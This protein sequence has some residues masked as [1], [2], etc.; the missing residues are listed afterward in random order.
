MS[1]DHPEGLPIAMDHEASSSIANERGGGGCVYWRT[2]GMDVRQHPAGGTIGAVSLRRSPGGVYASP[3]LSSVPS[4]R[5][6]EAGWS[7]R[8]SEK[9]KKLLS[10]K[11]GWSTRPCLKSQGGVP[12]ARPR[13]QGEQRAFCVIGR[14]REFW[15]GTP[16]APYRTISRAEALGL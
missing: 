6:N 8:P 10:Q 16:E 12:R 4:L 5:P 1:R 3:P 15:R 11:A 7:I 13:A 14:P 9:Q 2:P